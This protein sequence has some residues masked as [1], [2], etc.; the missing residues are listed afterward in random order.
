[1]SDQQRKTLWDLNP[2]TF[3]VPG[4]SQ[5]GAAPLPDLLFK[6]DAHVRGLYRATIDRQV[7]FTSEHARDNQIKIEQTKSNK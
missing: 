1:M 2:D 4:Q 5:N 3:V 7:F 6:R